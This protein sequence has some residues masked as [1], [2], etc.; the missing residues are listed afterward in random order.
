MNSLATSDVDCSTAEAAGRPERI[1]VVDDESAVREFIELSLRTGGFKHFT[2]AQDG[3]EV[4][5]VAQEGQPHLIIMD[6]IMPRMNGL[7][8]LRLLKE[9]SGTAKIPVI[10]TSG[11]DFDNIR[12]RAKEQA[13]LLLQKPFTPAQILFEVNRLLE[14]RCN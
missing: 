10:I 2:F 11:F 9:N 5:P 14:L 8:A 4:L 12:D 1:L 13:D 7:H 3:E 6:V